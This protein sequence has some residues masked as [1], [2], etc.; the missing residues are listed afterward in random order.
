MSAE[1]P[2]VAAARHFAKEERHDQGFWLLWQL[3]DVAK[4][5]ASNA[6]MTIR[7]KLAIGSIAVVFI[8]N[9]LLSLVTLH[10]LEGVWLDEVR[11]RVRFDLN[12]ARIAFRHR[13]ENMGSFVRAMVLDPSW[14][15]AVAKND[16][17]QLASL[18]R[19]LKRAGSFDLVSVVDLSG[20]VLA[21]PN[22]AQG[23]SIAENP[24]VKQAI[25][26]KHSITG[27][28]DVSSETLAREGDALAAAARIELL[29]SPAARQTDD[30]FSTNG[31]VMAAVVPV[32]AEGEPRAF[33]L[34]GQLLNRRLELVDAIS[35]LVFPSETYQG[36]RMGT[37]TI[38]LGDVRVAT[39]VID[40]G[41]S[42]AIG[43]RMRREVFDKVVVHG[44]TWDGPAQVLNDWYFTCYEPIHDADGRIVGAFYVGLLEAPFAHRRNV[45]SVMVL[46]SVLLATVVSLVL[47]YVVAMLVLRPVARIVAMA[48]QVIAGDLSARVGIRPPGEMGILCQA[49][50]G[51]ASAV[52]EREE[53][54]KAA[55]RQQ[56][57]Q[58]EKLASIGRLAAGVAHEI[59]NP[60]TGVLTF[61]HLLRDKPNMDDQD[62]QDLDLIIHETSRAADIVRNLLDFA[63][64]RAAIKEPLDINDVIRRTLRLIRNQKRFDQIEIRE[65][66][67]EDLPSVEGDMNQ[68]QQ[69]LL[70]LALNACEAMPSGGVITIRTAIEEGLIVVRLTD[71]GCG[72]KKEHLGQ[73]FEPFFTTKPVGKGTGLGLAVSYGIVHQHGGRLEVESQEGQ[74]ATFSLV[75]P[76]MPDRET[77]FHSASEVTDS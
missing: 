29:A 33:V 45:I 5:G 56:I 40:D 12:T 1:R 27:V 38:F 2:P 14:A 58:T 57:N 47:L 39:N 63:R 15:A 26:T 62:R 54:L 66:L 19:T 21:R 68:L 71:T 76:T 70:N 55:T 31:L 13:Q 44:E 30:K 72:I 10:Y 6:F 69:V 60:L 25:R 53:R 59:N 23:D 46:G 50:D 61:A 75:L 22:E 52:L 36:K 18:T 20:K 9:A 7:L 48:K 37:V 8:A 28:V 67:T 17:V 49:I 77:P 51:M 32:L 16:S 11:A 3:P 34:A 4:R 43:T 42:R 73:I 35:N 24:L 74:G 65:V 64:E 41:G